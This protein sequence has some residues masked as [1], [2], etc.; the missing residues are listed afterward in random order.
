MKNSFEWD[1]IDDIAKVIADAATI[2]ASRWKVILITLLLFFICTTGVTLTFVVR[3]YLLL[4]T[5][6]EKLEEVNGGEN[7]EERKLKIENKQ[8]PQKK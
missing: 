1:D 2:L 6:N 3:H 7:K 4:Q 5:V 8:V